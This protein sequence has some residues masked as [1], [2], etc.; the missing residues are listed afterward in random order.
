MKRTLSVVLAC[1]FAPLL[2]LGCASNAPPTKTL[3]VG[4]RVA[5]ATLLDQ[6][7]E[8]HKIDESVRAIF[9]T[10]EMEGGKVARALLDAEG[11]AFLQKHRA[12]YI[13]DISDMPG[14]IANLIAI[15]KMRSERPYP[16]LL[17]RDGRATAAFPS[18]EDRVTILLLHRLKVVGIQ[19]RGSV[20]GLKHAVSKR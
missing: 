8:P 19:Y 3:E 2:L 13:A 6:H 5:G 12:L 16:I 11:E 15:P 14:L 7:G 10:R 1:S 17:D 4:S 18:E 9:L 20:A